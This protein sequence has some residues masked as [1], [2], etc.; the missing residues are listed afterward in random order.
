MNLF[1]DADERAEKF[2]HQYLSRLLSLQGQPCAHGSLTVRSLLDMREHCLSE[3]N[4]HDP[5]LKQKQV[6]NEHAL[7]LLHDRLS[8]LESLGF[9][10]LHEQ[11]A[12]G[13]LAGNVFDWGAKEVA[14]LMESEHGLRFEDALTF[15]NP[16]PWLVDNL[17]EWKE[18]LRSK[19][20]HQCAAIFID[21]SG[22]DVI[23]GIFPFVVE[24]LR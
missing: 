14:L 24:L 2:K 18:R 13:L 9:E 3:F 15:V 11:L 17:D 6:E 4:F 8:S 10:A 1:L 16:R 7:N 22:M 21:N 5:Y 23:L 12:L 20:P 19:P